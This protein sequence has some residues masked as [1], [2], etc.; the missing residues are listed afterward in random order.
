MTAIQAK[1][2]EQLDRQLVETDD[3]AEKARIY[4]HAGQIY[5][6]SAE[7]DEACFFMT[8]AFVLAA[9]HGDKAIE[10]QARQFLLDHNRI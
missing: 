7:I 8:Q 5:S 9:H 1:L 2:L 4:M 3:L 10:Q 6:E